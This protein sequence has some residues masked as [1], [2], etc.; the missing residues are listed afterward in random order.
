MIKLV[1]CA[2]AGECGL[3]TCPHVR[4]HKEQIF[5]DESC[6]DEGYCR[7]TPQATK[8]IP[9]VEQEGGE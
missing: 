8:C 4:P 9:V 1:R 7:Q 3:I 6:A 5:I 2:K